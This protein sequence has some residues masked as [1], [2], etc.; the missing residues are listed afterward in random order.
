MSDQLKTP[1]EVR[2]SA[3]AKLKGIC[4]VY[5]NCD[6]L[7]ARLCQGHSYGSAIGIGG[8]GSGASFSNNFK[9]LDALHLEARLIGEDFKPDSTFSFF[10]TTL[11]M[12]I[13][14]ASVS[15]VGSFGGEAII[16]EK[17]FCRSVVLGCKEAKT[18]GWRG[19]SFNYTPEH[20]WGLDAIEEARGHGVQI[21]KPRDQIV[22][23]DFIKRAEKSK[24]VAV[25][26]DIDGHG[27]YAMAKNNQPV[28]RK[29]LKDLK[30]L[31]ASTSLPMIF[32]GIMSVSDALLAIEAGAKAICV[33]NHGGRVLDHTPGTAEV[34]PK[35]AKA[36]GSS[37]MIIA[38][39]GVRT[40]YDV[41][42]MLALGAQAVLVGR[43]VVRAAV[44]GG[45][46]GVSIH[47]NY[48]GTDLRRAMKM[49]GCETVNKIDPTIMC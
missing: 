41:I 3:R 34:L 22:L 6:G 14:A 48:L 8:V 29:S 47:M 11:D 25:G 18:L 13:M 33:S 27:S 15:G 17:E 12:P 28:Y 39:G 4:G 19:D 38:D 46:L 30:E 45:I 23:K 32:K 31:V 36:I 37:A 44:G 43:D 21:F 7:D 26:I 2:E 16:S 35:I 42:K 40:G 49:T 10:G 1:D 24:C 9:A 5:K 20:L